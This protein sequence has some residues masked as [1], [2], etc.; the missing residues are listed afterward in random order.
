M[1][2]SEG[3]SD[4]TARLKRFF[5]SSLAG[6]EP[7]FD[8]NEFNALALELF[9][10]QFA[11]NAPYRAWCKAL[12]V[13]PDAVDSWT[14][15]P[16]LPVAAFKEMEVTCIPEPERSHKF[17]S[18]G[19]SGLRRGRSIP[20][21]DQRHEAD[22][23]SLEASRSKHYHSERS[24]ELYASACWPW[25]ARHLLTQ[26]VFEQAGRGSLLC[27]TPGPV[28]APNSSLVHMFEVVRRSVNAPANVFAGSVEQDGSWGL[29]MPAVFGGLESAVQEGRAVCLLGTAFSFVHL[30]DWMKKTGVRLK[31]PPGSRIMETGGYKGKSR[32]LTRAELHGGLVLSL[33]V[34]QSCIVSE[35]GM[36]ELSSQAYDS[37]AG[38]GG[39][40]RLF[41]FPPWA[42][43]R[44]V[45]PETGREVDAG[46]TGLIQVFDLANAYSAMAL[47]TEDIGRRRGDGFEM[48]G[49]AEASEPRGCSL[50]LG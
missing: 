18:S 16:A 17:L 41:R 7:V 9:S 6:P 28:A 35:Y 11:G 37:V 39:P 22:N 38:V 8:E 2:L 49:R 15:I 27:L 44:I 21:L 23:I 1:Q 42:R 50:M 20:E 47:Q 31:L 24:I 36:S 19:T 43:V 4:F 12:R 30:L 40:D 33:G 25:F 5:I 32:V 34:V 14:G 13:S 45:S 10:L 3:F 48:L 46:E 26:P 29:D